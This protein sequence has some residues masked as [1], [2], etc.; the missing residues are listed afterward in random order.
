MKKYFNLSS[1]DIHG[2]PYQ[3]AFSL[4]R[5]SLSLLEKINTLYGLLLQGKR[6]YEQIA[7]IISDRDLRRTILSLAQK[8]NQYACELSSHLQTLGGISP[9]EKT[10]DLE[11]G[12][13]TKTLMDEN[14]I[15]KFCMANEKR[16]VK[17]YHEILSDSCLYEGLRSMFHYQLNGILCAF[18]QTKE[19]DSL[20]VH[21][22]F[23]LDRN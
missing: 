14:E 12:T 7:M 11:L 19:L 22:S 3:S 13:E 17:A 8:T 6:K 1:T 15:L 2:K 4:N 10:R 18:I 16:M 20:L 23:A 21:S 9:E 5:A